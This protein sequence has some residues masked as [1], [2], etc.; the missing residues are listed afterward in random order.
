MILISRH[1]LTTNA[2]GKLIDSVLIDKRKMSAASVNPVAT[3]NVQPPQQTVIVG[4][5]GKKICCACPQTK[6]E[7]DECVVTN[8]PDACSEKIEA[9]KRCLRE[10]GFQVE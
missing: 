2:L 4:K 5:S 6:R 7:R 1:V 8:G 3:S 9:H 10:D